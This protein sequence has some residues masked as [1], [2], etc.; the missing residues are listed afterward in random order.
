MN[1]DSRTDLQKC[2]SAK[3]KMGKVTV[4]SRSAIFCPKRSYKSE[5]GF[6]KVE[7]G[8]ACLVSENAYKSEILFAKVR[9]IFH[10]LKGVSMKH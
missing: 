10:I 7:L 5:F 3:L 9:L 1:S 8:K 2:K 4:L 6:A